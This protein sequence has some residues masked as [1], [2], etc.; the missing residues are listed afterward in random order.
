MTFFLGDF[1]GNTAKKPN[2]FARL[3][4]AN[5][6]SSKSAFKTL[7]I[8]RLRRAQRRFYKSREDFWQGGYIFCEQFAIR[9][10]GSFF[11]WR[12][13]HLARGGFKKGGL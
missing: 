7:K 6:I 4:R 12:A 13:P 10:P 11:F 1:S 2:F 3:R 9:R 8:S 5:E